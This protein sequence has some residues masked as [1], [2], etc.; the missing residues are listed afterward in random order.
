MATSKWQHRIFLAFAAVCVRVEAASALEPV[1]HFEGSY[2]IATAAPKRL[3]ATVNCVYHYPNLFAHE[4]L[5]AYALPP[6]FDGQP[7][8]RGRVRIVDA[9]DVEPVRIVDDSAM[10]Q[11][12]V[13]FN[14][15]ADTVEGAR[16]FT[17]EAIYDVTIARRSLE[18]GAPETP[19]RPLSRGER[20]VFLAPSSH[21]DF[22]SSKFRAW[23][24]KEGMKRNPD[25][26]DLDFAFRAMETVVR[27]HTYRF[28]LRS[29]R[30]ASAVCQAG[31]SD[32]G[33][34]STVYVSILRANGIPAR[35]LSGRNVKPDGTHVRM[36]F[37]AQDIGWVPADPA[38]AIAAHSARAG[39]GSERSDM[40]IMH[41]D[42]VRFEHQ[43]CWLQ[44]IGIVR[45]KNDEAGNASGMSLEHTMTIEAPFRR[46]PIAAAGR[47]G[48]KRGEKAKEFDGGKGGG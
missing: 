24:R 27:T 46:G 38:L 11:P 36:E 12:L 30:T 44:G 10:R 25:E 23:L 5:V 43:Y 35:C 20:S 26:R 42:L 29:N 4:W 47:V 9:P 16:G 3:R 40:V 8:A 34:L 7:K 15:M 6:E 13:T 2:H 48:A 17:V 19:V 14:W 39:F 32:C 22:T 37:Y 28:E 33:G 18:S 45:S 41:Y 1:K 31:W 21:F